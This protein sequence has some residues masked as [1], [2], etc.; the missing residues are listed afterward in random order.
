[1]R[2]SEPAASPTIGSFATFERPNGALLRP[3]TLTYRL[4]LVRTGQPARP[5][6][7]RAVSVVAST[8]AGAPTWLLLET[9][10]GS[11]VPT[12]DSLVL[13]RSDLSPVRWWAS[14]GS[15]R[16]SA[17]STRDTIYGAS[18]TYQGRSSFAVALPPGALLTAGMVER[19][20]EMLPLRMG[21]R[22]GASLLLVELGSPRAVPAELAVDREER[23][24]VLGR[25]EECWVVTLRAGAL[26]ERL[27]VTKE[28]ARVVRTEQAVT[29]GTLI[30][31]LAR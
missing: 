10:S 6:G 20:I 3:G 12:T 13:T 27:W 22:A 28:G 24:D 18:I 11:A 19:V 8:T 5:L 7:E 14:I 2:A 4:T 23:I 16:L 31:E 1:M 26:E 9:R 30:G 25:A 21:Y 15:A 29:G 17:S